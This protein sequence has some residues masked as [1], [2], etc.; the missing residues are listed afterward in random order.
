MEI[1]NFYVVKSTIFAQN[2][3][4]TMPNFGKDVK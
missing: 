4:D 1:F 2:I 3:Q